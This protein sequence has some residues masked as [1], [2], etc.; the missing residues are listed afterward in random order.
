[1]CGAAS[2]IAVGGH[3]VVCFGQSTMPRIRSPT[4]QHGDATCTAAHF[5]LQ[6]LGARACR[7]IEH[8]VSALRVK[9]EFELE[10]GLSG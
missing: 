10:N 6:E 4:S 7:F 9:G 1:M 2:G 5:V 3:Y 8:T